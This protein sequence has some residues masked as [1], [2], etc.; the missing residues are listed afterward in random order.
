LRILLFLQHC[1]QQ[2]VLSEVSFDVVG[3]CGARELLKI[4]MGSKS[5]TETSSTLYIS[6]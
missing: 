4:L 6:K 1:S 5:I 3:C 2:R